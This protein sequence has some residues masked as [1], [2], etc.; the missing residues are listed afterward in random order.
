MLWSRCVWATNSDYWVVREQYNA[1]VIALV[2]ATQ[3]RCGLSGSENMDCDGH[4]T[5]YCGLTVFGLSI[6][7]KQWRQ[8]NKAYGLRN[9]FE[10]KINDQLT[11]QDHSH[12]YKFKKKK[13]HE[14]EGWVRYSCKWFTTVICTTETSWLSKTFDLFKTL[15]RG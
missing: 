14:S 11:K 4:R 1:Y 2:N 7:S 10:V 9:A 6:Q 12:W 15:K 3:Q 13:S 8:K 5:Q